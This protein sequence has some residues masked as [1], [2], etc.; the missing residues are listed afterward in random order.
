MPTSCSG[1]AALVGVD[2]RRLGADDRLVPAQQQAQPEDVGAAAVQHQEGIVGAE[3]LAQPGGGLL[4]PRVGAVGNRVAR[5]R[6]RDRAQD[7]RM[8]ARVVVAAEALGMCHAH[9]P[10]TPAVRLGQQP[11][12]PAVPSGNVMAGR[13][14][15]LDT[16]AWAVSVVLATRRLLTK[17]VLARLPGGITP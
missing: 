11:V 2:V 17:R 8:N 16:S 10:K 13:D 3:G 4:G 12:L 14:R 1:R 7:R 5:V 9:E 6:V 15:M